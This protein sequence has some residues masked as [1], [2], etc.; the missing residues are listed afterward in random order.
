[1]GEESERQGMTHENLDVSHPRPRVRMTDGHGDNSCPLPLAF[2]RKRGGALKCSDSNAPALSKGKK[3]EPLTP[4][5]GSQSETQ[6]CDFVYIS[7]L[8]WQ[9]RS[10]SRRAGLAAFLPY[11]TSNSQ[12]WHHPCCPFSHIP[13]P[14]SLLHT[15]FPKDGICP[16]L[17]GSTATAQPR[18]S[19]L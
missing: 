17:A 2:W 6:R 18:P 7:V 10:G 12:P 13:H 15:A 1:M 4:L 9:P 8:W 19:T 11:V 14:T 16:C 3:R 5:A